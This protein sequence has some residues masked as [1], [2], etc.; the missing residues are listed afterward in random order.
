MTKCSSPQQIRTSHD[1]LQ[2]GATCIAIKGCS[3]G[4][5]AVSRFSELVLPVASIES[6][7]PQG[8]GGG[9]DKE[10]LWRVYVDEPNS[11]WDNRETKTNPKQPD[12]KRK[13]DGEVDRPP[14][15]APTQRPGRFGAIRSFRVR[16]LHFPSCCPCVGTPA[17]HR[18][19][20][21]DV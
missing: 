21:T 14:L 6:A 17:L 9:A 20:C 15:L 13:S 2:V 18:M 11:F 8:G 10:A 7:L 4:L 12:F 5:C 19:L 16:L 1:L 3:G